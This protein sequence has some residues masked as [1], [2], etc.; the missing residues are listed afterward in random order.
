L[1]FL[2]GLS[3]R[4]SNR[5]QKQKHRHRADENE[6]HEDHPL[7]TCALRPPITTRRIL[8]ALT[9][10]EAAAPNDMRSCDRLSSALRS[11]TIAR[12]S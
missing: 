1:P 4:R 5:P 3:V 11:L 10:C 2:I 6:F 9:N 8:L 12:R 7:I